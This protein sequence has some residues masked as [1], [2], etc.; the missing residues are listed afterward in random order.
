MIGSFASGP[1]TSLVAKKETKKNFLNV[2]IFI[3]ILRYLE[4]EIAYRPF[5]LFC[6]VVFQDYAQ[7]VLS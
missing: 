6:R 3:A 5:L 2:M 1:N 4:T 7:K